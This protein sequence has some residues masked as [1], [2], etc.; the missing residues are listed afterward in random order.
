MPVWLA[1]DP[2]GQEKTGQFFENGRAVPDGFAR[3]WEAIERLYEICL[4]DDV[5]IATFKR[6]EDTETSHDK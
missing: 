2:V 5:M 3:D 1:T 4:D 6:A